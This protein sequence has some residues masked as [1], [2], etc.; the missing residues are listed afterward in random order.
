MDVFSGCKSKG[1]WSIRTCSHKSRGKS[2]DAFNIEKRKIHVKHEPRVK[3]QDVKRWA[4]AS[5]WKTK[6]VWSSITYSHKSRGKSTD[7]FNV[8]KYI[9]HLKHETRGKFWDINVRTTDN[10]SCLDQERN[11][12]GYSKSVRFIGRLQRSHFIYIYLILVSK[13]RPKRWKIIWWT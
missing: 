3:F 8:E 4:F 6:E 11:I 5:G 1:V 10:F 12:A 13:K 2:T 7:A 9:I